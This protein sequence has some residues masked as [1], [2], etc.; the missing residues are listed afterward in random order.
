MAKALHRRALH[1]QPPRHT[2]IDP[3]TGFSVFTQAYLRRR[4]CCGN[5]CRHCPWGHRNVPKQKQKDDYD[6][7]DEKEEDKDL[8]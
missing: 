4:P 6:S 7:D 3:D 2:Y 1:M 5:K 8:F